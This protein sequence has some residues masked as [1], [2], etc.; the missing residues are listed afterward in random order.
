MSETETAT[1]DTPER[2]EMHVSFEFFPP[3]SDKMEATLWQA[4]EKLAPLEPRFVSVTYGAGGSTRERTHATVARIVRET[5]LTPAA[6]L[7]CVDATREEVDQVARDYL[8]AGVRHIVAL[9]GDPIAGIGTSYR[10]HPGGYA[11]SSD[12]VA[13]L[14]KIADFEISVSAYAERH[15]ESPDWQTDIDMLK[16]KVDAGA[17]R[18]IT[19]FFFNNDLFEAY[20]ERVRAAGIFIPIV[21]GVIPIHNFTQISKFAGMCGASMP[22][23]LVER[24]EGLE[25]DPETHKLVAAAVAAEQVDDLVS[26]GVTDFHFYTLNRADLVFAICHMLGIRPHMETVAA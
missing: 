21:P 26:R 25:H 9:R 14:K 2:P 3:K 8:A 6:H 18:A 4:I 7:T 16:R 19:Q 5:N 12:L 17:T 1:D 15:P 24:F 22:Q 13:A 11:Y 10:A 20:V 23:A